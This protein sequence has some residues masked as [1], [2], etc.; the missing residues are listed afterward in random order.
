MSHYLG[1]STV[2]ATGACRTYLIPRQHNGLDGA[3]RINTD[4]GRAIASPVG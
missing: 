1:R 3:A 2:D 4:P